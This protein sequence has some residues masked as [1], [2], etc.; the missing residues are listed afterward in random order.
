ML[1]VSYTGNNVHSAGNAGALLR[2]DEVTAPWCAQNWS[3]SLKLKKRSKK[4]VKIAL[5]P[6][7]GSKTPQIILFL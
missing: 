7:M 3:K 4:Y 5:G 6:L 2:G 1:S